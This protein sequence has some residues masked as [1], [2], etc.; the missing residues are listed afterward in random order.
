MSERD[1]RDSTDSGEAPAALP[2]E[3]AGSA[4]GR[5]RLVGRRL[6]I[7]GAGQNSYSL[8][9]PPIGNGRARSRS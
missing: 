6:L 4:P 9:D 3:S 8:L 7:V 1:E 2:P 5:G